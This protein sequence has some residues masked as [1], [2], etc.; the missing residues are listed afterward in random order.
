MIDPIG[1]ALEHGGEYSAILTFL[2]VVATL[3]GRAAPY[4]SKAWTDWMDVRKR[5]SNHEAAIIRA[6]ELR[7]QIDGVCNDIV[8]STPASRVVVELVHNGSPVADARSG[9]F[10]TAI[11]QSREGAAKDVLERLKGRPIDQAF[12]GLAKSAHD[13]HHV[14]ATP[15]NLDGSFM[16]DLYRADGI[17]AS[18]V[19]WLASMDRGLFLLEIQFPDEVPIPNSPVYREM[20]RGHVATLGA[21]LREHHGG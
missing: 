14:L 4:V 16:A 3:I 15:D 13:R 11:A 7:G 20:V 1:Y 6:F 21:L 5:E 9:L 8:A 12:R 17:G 19:H 2:I 10:V 18:D